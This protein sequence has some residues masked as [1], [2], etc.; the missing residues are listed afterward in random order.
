MK[1]RAQPSIKMNIQLDEYKKE[2][3]NV[4]VIKIRAQPSYK[5]IFIDGIKHT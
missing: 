5:N 3:K 1:I 4:K 2:M